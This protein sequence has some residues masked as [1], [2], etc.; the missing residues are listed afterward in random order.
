MTAVIAPRR[1]FD[2]RG[3][4]AMRFR[5]EPATAPSRAP[6]IA[7]N[8][9]PGPA[10][11]L[12]RPVIRA[13]RRPIGTP[14]VRD[15]QSRRLLSVRSRATVASGR[16]ISSHPRI[17]AKVW[18]HPAVDAHRMC[19]AATT[20]GGSISRPRG[21]RRGHVRF[22]A[23]RR[24]TRRS[25]QRIPERER[26]IARAVVRPRN[27]FRILAATPPR[28]A[29][30]VPRRALRAVMAAGPSIATAPYRDKTRHGRHTMLRGRLRGRTVHPH[31]NLDRRP[32]A[33]RRRGVE[34]RPVALPPIGHH[35]ASLRRTSLRR[36]QEDPVPAAAS[37][38]RARRPEEGEGKT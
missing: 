2:R 32:T 11:F 28:L 3:A 23:E 21:R 6:W 22:R 36:T 1:R 5:A 38:L 13:S 33:A 8:I 26:T 10:T 4:R 19:G 25:A 15:R 9:L 35:A 20:G 18:D 16:T 27:R 29:T 17:A 12:R 24:T 30:G 7:T 31:R 14:R 37:R 34:R